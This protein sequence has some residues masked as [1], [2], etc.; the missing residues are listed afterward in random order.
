MRASR[1]SG[2]V[3]VSS[4]GSPRRLIGRPYTRAGPRLTAVYARAVIERIVSFPARTIFMVVGIVLAVAAVLEVI[5]ISRHVLSWVF[6]S[7]FLALAM[8]PAVER[9]QRHL[10]RR[11]GAAV[12]NT[13]LGVL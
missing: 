6:I 9:L 1:P 13:Y 8:N 10:I 2:S 11:R 3:A 5:W 4:T 7:L 12:S